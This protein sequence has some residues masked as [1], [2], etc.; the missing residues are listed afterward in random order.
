M[1]QTEPLPLTSEQT[2][3]AETL[4]LLLG[5]AIANRYLDFCQ[6]VSGVLPLHTT[7]PLAAHALR[8]LE[9]LVRA[10]L[11]TPM[12]ATLIESREANIERKK[13]VKAVKVFGYGDEVLQDVSKQLKPRLNHRLQI[14]RICDRLGLDRDADVVLCWQASRHTRVCAPTAF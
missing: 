6:L 8:E 10:V 5:P 13:A 9:A 11:A 7:L 4:R 14:E 1:S 12:D 2:A 3:T